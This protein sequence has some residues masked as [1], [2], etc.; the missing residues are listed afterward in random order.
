MAIP[1]LIQG[2]QHTDE[3]G[4]LRFVNDFSMCAVQRMYCIEP[5]TDLIRAWQGHQ[6][7]TKWFFVS[8]GRFQVQ[9]VS[10]Q[11]EEARFLFDLTAEENQVLE[12]PPGYYN[13]FRACNAD[14][15]LMVFSDKLLK[16]STKDDLR[17]TVSELTW[18]Q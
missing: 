4:F 10:I 3:R 14:S 6:H 15:Q 2:N 12:I 11:N 5:T 16:D 9:L 8:R 13:G 1:T 7:E 18:Q 17:K